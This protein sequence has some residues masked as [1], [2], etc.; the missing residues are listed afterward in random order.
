M[1]QIRAGEEQTAEGSG[2]GLALCKDFIERGHSGT[3]GFDE[4][5]PTGLKFYFE[6][7]YKLACSQIMANPPESPAPIHRRTAAADS[8]DIC[9]PEA[10]SAMSSSKPVGAER[11]WDFDVMIV[12]DSE[13][14]RNLISKSL[15]VLGVTSIA[16]I[17]G[18]EVGLLVCNDFCV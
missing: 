14:T 4:I 7:D 1:L 3:I 17:N 18:K 11:W 10:E 5:R 13:M 9:N 2:L 8:Q 15:D 6:I 16:C 12:D